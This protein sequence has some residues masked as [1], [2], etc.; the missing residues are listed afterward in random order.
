MI[1]ITPS[2]FYIEYLKR[3]LLYQFALEEETLNKFIPSNIQ[4][5]ISKKTKKIRFIYLE[6]KM[7]GMIRPHDGFFL[8]TP[9]SAKF[10]I[11]TTQYPKL[12]V[13][14]LPEI[15]EFIQAGRNV[16]AKHVV[17][18]DPNLI[19]FSEIIVVD[20]SDVPLALGKAL[21]NR[22][23]MLAF[24]EGVAVRVRKSV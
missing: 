17:D 20:E 5:E 2:L 8:F 16:F 23:E 10:L 4:I 21:L 19:P 18:C 12:R 22:E 13:V 1:R 14:V 15:S 6:E 11:K 3:R 7:W 9:D 24:N